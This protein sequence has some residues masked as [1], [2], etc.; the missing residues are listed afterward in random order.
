MGFRLSVTGGPEEVSLDER[1]VKNVVFVSE[2]SEDSNARA[3]DF[4]VSMKIW[5]KMLYI[6]GGEGD[7]GTLGLSKWAVVPSEK[8]DCYRNVSVEVIAAGQVV[9]KYEVPNAFMMDYTEELDDETGVGTFY[10]HVKQKKDEN[11]KV[12]IEGGFAG[13]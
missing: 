1:S 5:G 7:D 13:E 10:M 9:R 2:S 11:A 8:A 6:L 4:G 12:K 3:T